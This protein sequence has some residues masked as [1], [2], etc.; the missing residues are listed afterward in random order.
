MNI[1][2]HLSEKCHKINGILIE[3]YNFFIYYE[4]IKEFKHILRHYKESYNK[5]IIKKNS[6]FYK[7]DMVW[8]LLKYGANLED[9]IYFDFINKRNKE[10]NSYLTY[11][12]N[13]KL[14]KKINKSANNKKGN[15]FYTVYANKTK[16][17]INFKDYISRDWINCNNANEDDYKHFF[18]KHK[19]AILKPNN[20][21]KGE[22]I[23]FITSDEIDNLSI[24]NSNS[25]L[26]EILCNH[27]EI[28]K[29][30][31]SCLSTIRVVTLIDK[32]NIIHFLRAIIRFSLNNSKVDNLSRGGCACDVDTKSG[33]IISDGM[34]LN[35]DII[36]QHP[37]SQIT[38]KGFQLPM[39]DRVIETISKAA[40]IDQSIKYMGWDVAITDN[41]IELIEGNTV[42]GVHLTQC[43]KIGIYNKIKSLI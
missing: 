30:S 9:Y 34:K 29:I 24:K 14:S 8:C 35:G 31:S 20:G 32:D 23:I 25:I 17:N 1:R 41:K 28:S 2:K 26:E 27:H 38:F 42:P 16:F 37:E 7:L 13:F 33:R 3:K 19:C 15:F 43:D 12:R 6:F 39:W 5:D 40:Y 11:M 21:T 4:F 36:T 10:R 22:G 18:D